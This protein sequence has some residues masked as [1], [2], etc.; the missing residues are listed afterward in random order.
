MQRLKRF[1]HLSMQERTLVFQAVFAM[2]VVRLSLAWLSL[3]TIQRL[4][5]SIRRRSSRARSAHRI[6]WAVR[7]A[8][9]F[10][11]RSTCLVQAW[12]QEI[13]LYF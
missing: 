13:T 3:R 11:P 6:V 4:A 8:A 5:V 7:S 9:P 10:V 2:L 12:K 1:L